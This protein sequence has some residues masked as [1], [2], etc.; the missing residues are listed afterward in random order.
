MENIEK[1]RAKI[2]ACDDEII[3]ILSKRMDCIDEIMEYKKETGMPILQ[4]E[5]E[6]K[7]EIAL[8]K[9]LKDNKYE[10]EIVNIFRYIVKNS[11]KYQAKNL[12]PYNITLIGFMGCGKSTIGKYLSHILEMEYLETDDF[13]EKR[14]DMT[15]NEI[16]QRRGEEYFR[17]CET[18]VLRELQDKKG[19]IIS[20]G[21]GIPLRKENVDLMKK[22]SKVILLKANAETT[23]DRVRYSNQRPL[24]NG[25]MNIEYIK[26]LME[27]RFEKYEGI[28]DIEI[29][30]DNKPIHLI[31]EEVVS[32]LAKLD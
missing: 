29:D 22:N 28:A 30:T 8:F 23:Y 21:G 17:E 14:E 6:G 4:P 32:K 10:D 9:K 16:F 3:K 24:L 25:N 26:D 18:K 31:A 1:I 20:C 27:K 2:S 5:Y 13:I 7:K 11:K 12:F 19:I 15:I